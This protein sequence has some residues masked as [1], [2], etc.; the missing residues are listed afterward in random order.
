MR[1]ALEKLESKEDWSEATI[2]TDSK[3][4][5]EKLTN[6]NYNS[7]DP[8]INKIKEIT[9]RVISRGKQREILLVSSHCNLRSNDLADEQAAK[10]DT[11]QRKTETELEAKFTQAIIKNKTKH[12][13]QIKDNNKEICTKAVDLNEE[14]KLRVEEQS[15]EQA[16]TIS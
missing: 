16:I 15:E 14:D 12:H 8:N 13:L 5:C 9:D 7:K 10:L 11:K 2:I 4:L 6:Y 3:S 1:S